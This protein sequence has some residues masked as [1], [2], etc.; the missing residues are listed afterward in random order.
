MILEDLIKYIP[1]VN[2]NYYED[3]IILLKVILKLNLKE[4]VMNFEDN[5]KGF[6][7]TSEEFVNKIG[8]DEAV[9]NCGHSGA[10]FALC[11]RVCQKTLKKYADNKE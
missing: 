4:N 9:L 3:I 1:E 2:K 8:N 5:E 6:S 10:S 7:W 11:L